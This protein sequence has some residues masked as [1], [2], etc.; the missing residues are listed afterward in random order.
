MLP[1]AEERFNVVVFGP[2]PETDS[3]LNVPFFLLLH[4][5]PF[6]LPLQL[7]NSFRLLPVLL[8][9]LYPVVELALYFGYSP[10]FDFLIE[11]GCPLPSCLLQSLFSLLSRQLGQS[12]FF[13]LH[14]NLLAGEIHRLELSLYFFVKG[15]DGFGREE[16]D[17]SRIVF[18]LVGEV[19]GFLF[20]VML[21][22]SNPLVHLCL[23]VSVGAFPLDF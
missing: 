5:L 15:A 2:M 3:F 16:A 23:C 21:D 17:I 11:L 20:P 13:L 4:V 12:L 9:F 14:D 18:I 8:S 10:V 19:E 7:F 6:L 22:D 1:E